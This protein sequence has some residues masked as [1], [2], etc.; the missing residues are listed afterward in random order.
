MA[1]NMFAAYP[2]GCPP[3]V[4]ERLLFERQLA[5]PALPETNVQ[6]FCRFVLPVILLRRK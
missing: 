2:Y 1:K 4:H 3:A 5:D 6:Y